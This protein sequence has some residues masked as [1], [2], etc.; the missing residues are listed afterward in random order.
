M[1]RIAGVDQGRDGKIGVQ[2][3]PESDTMM[4]GHSGQVD[5][6]YPTA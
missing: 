3:R 2:G 6:S 4:Q 1:T 5:I